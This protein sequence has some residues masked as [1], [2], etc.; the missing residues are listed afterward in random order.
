M[1]NNRLNTIKIDL[2][3]NTHLKHVDVKFSCLMY[4]NTFL[5]CFS[6]QIMRILSLFL[7]IHDKIIK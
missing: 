7:N 6:Y 5:S 4:N 3:N 2:Y 1:K